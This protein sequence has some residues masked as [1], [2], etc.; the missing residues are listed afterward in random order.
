MDFR[1]NRKMIIF[2]K[3]MLSL[4][5]TKMVIFAFILSSH[6]HRAF[7]FRSNIWSLD[8]WT[9]WTSPSPASPPTTTVS[10]PC[11]ITT[12]I[13]HHQLRRGTN[14]GHQPPL[15]TN[16]QPPV[17][18]TFSS[19]RTTTTFSSPCLIRVTTHPQWKNQ[20]T[21]SSLIEHY[22]KCLTSSISFFLELA[23]PAFEVQLIDNI[24]RCTC[25]C[26]NCLKGGPTVAPSHWVL[27]VSKYPRST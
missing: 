1:M 13:S 16:H 14:N 17:T 11:H 27:S 9:F 22:I 7:K 24:R 4:D 3:S 5:F 15:S 20:I 23:V 25:D 12:N 6:F 18:P 2:E 21:K 10:S 26:L 19:P 8:L